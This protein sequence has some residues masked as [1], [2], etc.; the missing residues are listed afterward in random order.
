MG[1]MFSKGFSMLFDNFLS[2]ILIS[3]A[4]LLPAYYMISYYFKKILVL[5]LLRQMNSPAA[6]VTSFLL[7]VT[8]F[9]ASALI[10]VLIISFIND[11]AHSNNSG[12]IAVFRRIFLRV[13]VLFAFIFIL[14]V[15]LFILNNFPT[16]L[17]SFTG[18]PSLFLIAFV[19]VIFVMLN[20]S[21]ALPVFLCER[22]GPIKAL[23]R[24]WSLI[25]GA[26]WRTFFLYLLAGFIYALVLLLFFVFVYSSYGEYFQQASRYGQPPDMATAFSFLNVMIWL[27]IG[28]LFLINALFS[29]LSLSVYYSRKSQK[30]ALELEQSVEE[31]VGE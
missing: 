10:N 12:G 9:L 28:S 1:E 21:I 30:E 23:A 20:L 27:M 3:A 24:S 4:V 13:P 29:V 7:F 8:M 17:L 19:P 15:L 26:R 14:F 2:V 31:Y 25:R 6:F 22:T 5:S 11:R 16:L 18:L